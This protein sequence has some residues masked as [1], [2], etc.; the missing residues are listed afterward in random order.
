MQLKQTIMSVAILLGAV[1]SAEAETGA[2]DAVPTL[3]V[4]SPERV[5]TTVA[6]LCYTFDQIKEVA[7]LTTLG[8]SHGEAIMQVNMHLRVNMCER[9]LVRLWQ[10]KLRTILHTDGHMIAI[11]KVM[12]S[13][14]AR[15]TFFTMRRLSV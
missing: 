1:L 13:E 5:V 10:P 4:P 9:K 3:K 15:Y 12:T 2:S 8:N 6:T 14:K 7:R 11:V